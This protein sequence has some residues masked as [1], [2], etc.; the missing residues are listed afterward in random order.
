MEA[1]SFKS[2][3]SW[4]YASSYDGLIFKDSIVWDVGKISYVYK[5][6]TEVA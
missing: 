1:L 3:S 4:T 6:L 2:W 5:I